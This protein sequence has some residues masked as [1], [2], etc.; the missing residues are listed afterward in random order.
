MAGR[1]RPKEEFTMA[2]EKHAGRRKLLSVNAMLADEVAA[3]VKAARMAGGLT[4]P[5][6]EA[7]AALRR[8]P[9]TKRRAVVRAAMAM[10]PVMN[11]TQLAKRLAETVRSLTG[12][13][14]QTLR[15]DIAAIKAGHDK[16]R[17]K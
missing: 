8:V 11:N 1:G 17:K 2:V 6:R 13:S 4:A 7:G 15:H 9:V 5:K 16:L 14:V 10:A 12:T 3:A